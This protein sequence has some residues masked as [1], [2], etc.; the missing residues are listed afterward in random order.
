LPNLSVE[1]IDSPIG[2]RT[3][4]FV[5]GQENRRENNGSP[6]RRLPGLVEYMS[7]AIDCTHHVE[8]VLLTVIRSSIDEIKVWLRCLRPV[9]V[10]QDLINPMTRV[11]LVLPVVH[12][13]FGIGPNGELASYRA[14]NFRMRFLL[15][16][17]HVDLVSLLSEMI[18]ERFAKAILGI[19]SVATNN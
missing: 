6:G 14:K 3:Q 10:H 15:A 4:S 18:T 8:V 2:T 12:A 16:S 1:P 13:A 7:Q 5:V 11:A 9:K 17:N 19:R